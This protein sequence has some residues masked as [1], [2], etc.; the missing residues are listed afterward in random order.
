MSTNLNQNQNPATDRPA[1]VYLADPM[2]SWCWGFSPVIEGIAEQYRD[3][4]R[5]RVL[6]G[7]LYPGATEPMSNQFK[8]A[9]REHWQHV[10]RRAGQPFDFGFFDRDR[11]V[12]DSEPPC[13]ALV[14]VREHH[15]DL[16]LPML[17]ALHA[18]FYQ[19]NRDITDP[20][21][22]R[23]VA[24][25]IGLDR[26][27]FAQA[28]ESDAMRKRAQDDFD[29]ARELGMRGLPTLLGYDQSAIVTITEGYC[30]LAEV[31]SDLDKWLAQVA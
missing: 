7:G 16:T 27:E 18:A 6:A 15:P 8:A 23:E 30:G 12:Y 24:A 11:F 20:A 3:N 21:V 25:G 26:D 28:F 10:N 13:R 9:V 17:R 2:C 29:L 31:K 1:L 14:T 5:I 4:A 22:L 19:E